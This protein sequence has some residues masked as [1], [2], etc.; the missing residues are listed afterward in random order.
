MAFVADYQ[1]ES[2][3]NFSLHDRRQRAPL[4]RVERTCERAQERDVR[5]FDACQQHLDRAP[6][7]QADAEGRVVRDPVPHPLG[8]SRREEC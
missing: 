3:R 2:A 7:G 1:R 4:S 5:H 6:A 8:T